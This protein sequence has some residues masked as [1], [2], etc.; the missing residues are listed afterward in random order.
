MSLKAEG[1]VERLHYLQSKHRLHARDMRIYGPLRPT[2]GRCEASWT[3]EDVS[4]SAFA[5]I[6]LAMNASRGTRAQGSEDMQRN[7]WILPG[8]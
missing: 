8:P 4:D 1:V 5:R 2:F 7:S 3:C 6:R